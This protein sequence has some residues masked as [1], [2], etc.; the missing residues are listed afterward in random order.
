VFDKSANLTVR[1]AGLPEIC[2]GGNGAV[3]IKN[4]IFENMKRMSLLC[5][6]WLMSIAAGAQKVYFIYVESDT[7]APF[8]IRLGDKVASSTA[9]GYVILANLRDS[10]YL[11]QVGFAGNTAE[12]RFQ[13]A[14]NKEDKGF[15]LKQIGGSWNLFDLQTLTLNKALAMEGPS[16][17]ESQRMLASADPF[18]KLL[19]QASDDLSLLGAG[20]SAPAV[21]VAMSSGSGSTAG[22]VLIDTVPAKPATVMAS[23]PVADSGS[24]AAPSSVAE[25][26]PVEQPYA[27]TQVTRR[28]E[29]STTEG[30]GLV[31]IDN[32]GSAS[33]T[34]RLLIPNP[35][36]V[37]PAAVSPDTARAVMETQKQ[38]ASG[39]DAVTSNNTV[40]TDSLATNV[41]QVVIPATD[42]VGLAKTVAAP[43]VMVTNCAANAEDKDFLKLRRNMAA[44]NDEAAMVNVARKD[45][46]KRCYTTAQVQNLGS[47]FLTDI[48]KYNFLEAAYGHVSDPAGFNSLGA[49]LKDPFYFNR[50]KSLTGQ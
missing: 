27:R 32:L 24:A 45:F 16:Q 40:A 7:G 3:D 13:V 33:D 8:Y 28:S 30:F 26:G 41:A 46:K 34:I 39:V 5:L 6:L 10:S 31:F 15:I 36:F 12:S 47:L 4:S 25:A 29:S 19:V 50:F 48:A 44:A 22:I 14:L 1:L 18:T 49:G 17:E 35:K 37:Q 21:D 11:L 42:T 43:L 38:A 20:P 2:T 23:T 9:S